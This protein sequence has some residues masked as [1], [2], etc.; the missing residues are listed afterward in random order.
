[1]RSRSH[2]SAFVPRLVDFSKVDGGAVANRISEKVSSLAVCLLPLPSG[3]A[4]RPWGTFQA[5]LCLKLNATGL[6]VADR[7][8]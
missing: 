5:A 7:M 2:V 6:V 8:A 1:V 3:L 4:S